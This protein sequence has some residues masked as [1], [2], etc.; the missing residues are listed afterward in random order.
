MMR[1]LRSFYLNQDHRPPKLGFF[2]LFC[3]GQQRNVQRF[4]T[5]VHSYC[6]LLNLN[7]L[8]GGVLVAVVVVVCLTSQIIVFNVWETCFRIYVLKMTEILVHQIT[9]QAVINLQILSCS[10]LQCFLP[11]FS[12]PPLTHSFFNIEK[13]QTKLNVCLMA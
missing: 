7:P 13:S 5:Y 9:A 11:S 1:F 3:R 10:G 12:D 8:V 4:I 2:T 6:S